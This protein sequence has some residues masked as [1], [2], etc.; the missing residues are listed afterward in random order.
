MHLEVK[1][2]TIPNGGKGLFTTI[3]RAKNE[4]LLE[5]TGD[6][7]TQRELDVEYPGDTRAVYVL[8]LRSGDNPLYIDSKDPQRSS[9]A[10]YANDCSNSGNVKCN[11]EFVNNYDA[12]ITLVAT[13][14]I[15]AG[16]EI[17]ASYGPQYW[18]AAE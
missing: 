13:R 15:A 5:Y 7:L 10:R 17:F 9:V 1:Q 2:S 16:E 6:I 14:N 18:S 8:Q 4:V 12:W 3:D 11:A